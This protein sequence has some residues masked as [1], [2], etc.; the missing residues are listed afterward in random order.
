MYKMRLP[1]VPIAE[2]SRKAVHEAMVGAGL[3]N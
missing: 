1:M 3:I 2:S